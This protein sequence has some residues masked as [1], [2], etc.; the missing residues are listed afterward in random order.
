MNPND[1]S[2]SAY[3]LRR[4]WGPWLDVTGSLHDDPEHR[5]SVIA[6]NDERCNCRGEILCSS[7]NLMPGDMIIKVPQSVSWP[8]LFMFESLRKYFIG[9]AGFA[10]LLALDPKSFAQAT[11]WCFHIENES[12]DYLNLFVILLRR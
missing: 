10:S 8:M 1:V 12:S 5:S 6:I 7:H 4:E 2:S 9:C 3:V 11:E